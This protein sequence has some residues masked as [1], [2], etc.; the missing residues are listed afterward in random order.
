[1]RGS[2]IATVFFLRIFLTCSLAL[3][4]AEKPELSKKGGIP[5][6][7]RWKSEDVK[8]FLNLPFLTDPVQKTIS[9]ENIISITKISKEIGAYQLKDFKEVYS[10]TDKE[11]IIAAS[12]SL[13]DNSS[14]VFR[15]TVYDIDSWNIV[16]ENIYEYI[17]GTVALW[18]DIPKY[19]VIENNNNI[20]SIAYKGT[21][22]QKWCFLKNEQFVIYI[23][24][25][26]SHQKNQTE[27]TVKLNE[28]DQVIKSIVATIK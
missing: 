21:N 22:P 6:E 27:T 9:I 3:C 15:V 12:F 19:C 5:S 26:F 13:Y 20:Y 7:N 14:S 11:K 25:D 16:C 28:I 2:I 18:N 8:S 24:S 23:E 10:K 17:T 4:A 1:M